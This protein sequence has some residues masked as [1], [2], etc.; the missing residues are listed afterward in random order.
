MCELAAAVE[1][2]SLDLS[3]DIACFMSALIAVAAV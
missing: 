3:D 1:V 2:E